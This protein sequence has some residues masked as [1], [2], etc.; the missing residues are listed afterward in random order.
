MNNV[1]NFKQIFGVA[2]WWRITGPDTAVPHH[3][4]ATSSSGT[5]F[6]NHLPLKIN[7]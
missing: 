7:H 6:I 3:I 5:Q 2:T 4:P 1:C